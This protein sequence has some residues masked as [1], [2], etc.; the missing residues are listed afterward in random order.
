MCVLY[1]FQSIMNDNVIPKLYSFHKYIFLQLLP[2]QTMQN[3]IFIKI[4]AEN[5]FVAIIHK[6]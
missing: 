3:T 6:L 1:P 2:W 4:Y 5:R